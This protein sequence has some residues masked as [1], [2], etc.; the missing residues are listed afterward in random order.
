MFPRCPRCAP[1]GWHGL[2]CTGLRGVGGLSCTCPSSV[3]PDTYDVGGP[4]LPRDTTAH[5]GT[6]RPEVITPAPGGRP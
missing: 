6:G 3:P 1:H 5:N 2:P 4:L